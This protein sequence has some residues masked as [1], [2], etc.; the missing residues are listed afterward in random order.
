MAVLPD[1]SVEFLLTGNETRLWKDLH[2]ND[3]RHTPTSTD[4]FLGKI[5][6]AVCGNLYHRCNHGGHWV[7][8]F[9]MG[10]KRKGFSCQNKNIPDSILRRISAYVMGT[11]DFDEEAFGRQVQ[12]IQ[13]M[14]NGD[15]VYHFTDGRTTLW[16][17]M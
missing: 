12:E 11:E 10:K 6:C 1:G 8:W 14:E 17:K 2:L 3:S 13:V 16:E 4:A 9:C 15:L 7:Y 5:R